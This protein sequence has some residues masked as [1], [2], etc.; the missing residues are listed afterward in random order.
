[1]REAHR[2][3]GIATALLGRLLAEARA[4]QASRAYLEVRAGNAAAQALYEACGFC[5]VGRRRHYYSN[6]QEDALIMAA[7]IGESA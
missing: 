3:T 7:E 5:V 1:V 4:C 6:P 2:R